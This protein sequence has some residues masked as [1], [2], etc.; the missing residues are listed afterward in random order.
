MRTMLNI[1]SPDEM[2]KIHQA[3]LKILQKTGI[4]V[5]SEKTR[6]QLARHGAVL[7]G[8][9]VRLPEKLVLDAI[10]AA[11][12]QVLLAGRSP[13]HDIV[14]PGTDFPQ[15]ALSG[16]S[17]VVDDWRTGESRNSTAKDLKEF[18]TIAD[19]LD[20]VTFFWP[21]VLPTEVPEIYDEVLA[22]AIAFENTSKHVQC[23]CSSESA[24][25]WQVEMGRALAGG[26]EELRKRPVFSAL[27]SP[28]SPLTFEMH[29]VEALMVLA[30]AG[31]PVVP[32]NMALAS[33]TAPATIAGV[34]ALVNAEQLATLTIINS[35]RPGSP[36]IYST[37]S[38][39]AS[40]VTGQLNYKA[41]EYKIISAGCAQMARHYKL[42]ST[43]AHGTT[44]GIADSQ[45]RFEKDVL[46]VAIHMMSRTDMTTWFGGCNDGL[47]ASQTQMLYDAEVFEHACAYLRTYS[48]D[49]ETL[50]TDV[51]DVVG[52]GG[53]FLSEMHTVRHFKKEL[54]LQD[55]TVPI[56]LDPGDESF[57]R[58]AENKAQEIL[59]SHT[60]L[61]LEDN[62]KEEIAGILEQ[63]RQDLK[64]TID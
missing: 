61:P 47:S 45:D 24:A 1:L 57:T 53:H 56:I 19:Y 5:H 22:L 49:D 30:E 27:G 16:Y 42:P 60:P 29:T 11:P 13:E 26:S 37:D 59:A 25:R 34:L 15:P 50:A 63:A 33:T 17:T 20:T 8:D 12:D 4:R 3:S 39:P 41:P 35:V 10:E 46:N 48:V 14:V 6:K 58:K 2:E 9:L 64:I 62:K 54:W 38:P 44:V 43:V 28:V 55:H 18:A 21:I 52:P 51:I 23:S 36:M 32:M 31:V 40:V 7:E